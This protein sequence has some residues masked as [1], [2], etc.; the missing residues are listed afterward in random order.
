MFDPDFARAFVDGRM[1]TGLNHAEALQ[2][3]KCPLLIL[4]AD[5]HRYEKHGLVGAM[6][7]NDAARIQQ[8]APHAKYQKIS[9]N[10]VIHM[11]RSKEFIAAIVDFS[12]NTQAS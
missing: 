2:K 6:D 10:H 3:L 12:K 9:A 7:D 4:H 11:Y 5:W 8:L 1:Y